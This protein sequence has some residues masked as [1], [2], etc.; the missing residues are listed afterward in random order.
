MRY[1]VL[2][3]FLL[4]LFFIGYLR[5]LKK[6]LN[7]LTEENIYLRHFYEN[8]STKMVNPQ[9]LKKWKIYRISFPFIPVDVIKNARIEWVNIE[10]KEVEGYEVP[11]E[12]IK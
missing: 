3:L 12:G 10:T 5:S 11:M 2:I 1:L 7:M 6:Q 4:L 8:K 9:E